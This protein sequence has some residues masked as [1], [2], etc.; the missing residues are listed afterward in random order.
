MSEYLAEF[1][2]AVCTVLALALLLLLLIRY[3][4][5]AFAGL[6]TVSLALGLAT[7]MEPAKVVEA[8]AKGVGDI[9]RNV[10]L[11]LAL[12]AMLGRML[13]ISGAAEVIAG[14]L[15]RALGIKRAPLAILFAGY[16]IGIPVMF[17]VGFLLLMPIMWRLQKQ[18]GQSLLYFHLPLSC[19]LSVTHSLI[20][21]HP[22]IAGAVGNLGGPDPSQTMIQTL[23][24]GSLLSIPMILIG[25]FGYGLFWA[26]RRFINCPELLS[27]AFE[28]KSVADTNKPSLPPVSFK[29]SVFIVVLPLL[30]GVA[31]F[32]AKLL[33]APTAIQAKGSVP[34]A[35]VEPVPAKELPSWLTQPIVPRENLPFYLTWLA[36]S[37]LAWLE[38]LGKPEIALLVPTGLAF[39]LLGLR[40]GLYGA[41]LAKVAEDALRDVGSIAFL[42][43]AAG[44]FKEVIQATGAG[45]IIA[46]Q[47]MDLPLTPVA[48]AYIIGALMRI[49]LGSATAAIITASA[50]LQ[51]LAVQLPGQETL[52][53]LAVATGVVI[54]SQPADSGFWMNKE[55][56][57]LTVR[58]TLIGINACRILMSV[59]GLG[60]LLIVEAWS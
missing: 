8:M 37:P 45:E 26:R 56:G 29:V 3:Q 54:L 40:R 51:G 43:G 22:G 28:Q 27:V 6:L 30:L 14:T 15:I 57:N 50:L 35:K 25:W 60:L 36:H 55:Y 23:V 11:L 59:V 19:S 13:E 12:G 20:P 2:P 49:S 38:F 42:F 1:W 7:G 18:T 32:G 41:K 46:K 4:M 58:E 17:N 16:L 53:V 44:G 9:L 48:I 10:A 39:W 24:F 34:K 21:T 33:E 52:L 31:G 47:M 5:H